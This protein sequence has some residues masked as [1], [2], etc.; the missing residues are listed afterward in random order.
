MLKSSSVD[1]FGIIESLISI[2]LLTFLMVGGMSIYMYSNQHLKFMTHQRMAADLANSKMEYIKQLGYSGLPA[3]GSY[4]LP[5]P[6]TSQKIRELPVTIRSH[7][8]ADTSDP[9]Y[10]THYKQIEVVVQWTQPGQSAPS[11]VTL[12]SFITE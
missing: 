7:V 11:N 3:A 4:L 2:M 5:D 9:G 8:L 1:G 6:D 10:T 12:D